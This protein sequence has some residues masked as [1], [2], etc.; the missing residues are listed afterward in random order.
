MKRTIIAGLLA[1]CLLMS[2]NAFAQSSSYEQ[3]KATVYELLASNMPKEEQLAWIKALAEGNGIT[4]YQEI[5]DSYVPAPP[6][7]PPVDNEDR[8]TTY[9][10][11]YGTYCANGNFEGHVIY[12]VIYKKKNSVMTGLEVKKYSIYTPDH[13]GR[14]KANLKL[15]GIY[16]SNGKWTDV[17]HES[18]DDLKQDGQ[19][20]D[21]YLGVAGAG[22]DNEAFRGE[23]EFVFDKSGSDPK[24]TI[25]VG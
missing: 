18:D 13:S 19:W 6:P 12:D 14:S 22:Y 25:K 23:I 11:E 7:P 21:L 1:P 16:N 10:Q 20:H 9:K 5:I 8:N 15:K 17:K 24:C 3:F 2:A 4:N